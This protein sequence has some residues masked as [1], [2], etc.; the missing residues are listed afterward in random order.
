MMPDSEE[1]KQKKRTAF[2][3]LSE[4]E[5]LMNVYKDHDYIIV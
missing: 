5:L 3:N 2:F 4:Q 1:Q